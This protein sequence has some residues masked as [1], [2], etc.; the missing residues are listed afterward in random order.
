MSEPLEENLS[1]TIAGAVAV[2]LT[3]HRGQAEEEPRTGHSVGR[4]RIMRKPN[5]GRLFAAQVSSMLGD[6]FYLVAMPFFVLDRAGAAG[7]GNVLLAF[8]LARL[9]SLPL[10]GSL[11]DRFPRPR[12]ILSAYLVKAA[13]L[14]VL[15]IAQPHSLPVIMSLT[16]SLGLTE[17]ASLPASMSILPSLVESD[18]LPIANSLMSTATM[19]ISLLG[20]AVAGAVV[21]VVGSGFAL[22]VDAIIAVVAIAAIC[23]VRLTRASIVATTESV[24]RPT[25]IVGLLRSNVI[26]RFSVIVTGVIALTYAGVTEIALPI[27]TRQELGAGSQGYGLLL[28]GI[29][30][31]GVIGA[32]G[33]GVLFARRR[34]AVIALSVGIFQGVVMALVPTGR[35][36]WVS[37]AALVVVGATQ[38]ALNVFFV[39]TLQRRVRVED[40]GK[41]MSAVLM[42]AYGGFPVAVTL[43]G[44]SIQSIGVATIFAIGGL[45]MA[46]GFACGFLSREYRNL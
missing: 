36:L 33:A 4:L 29:G 3:E 15:A 25:S 41:A 42:A 26:L 44:H 18:D 37:L 27:Y 22:G 45:M 38:T 14:A 20:P 2:P 34:P 13:L 8:G 19:T 21:S 39:T 17:G 12:V 5:F 43:A 9:V 10:G 46:V 31:G 35:L 28:A 24:S 6:Q 30:T 7:L 11:A 16:A 32:L 1:T 40:M 23:R